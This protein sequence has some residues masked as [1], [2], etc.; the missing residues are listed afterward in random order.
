MTK[1]LTSLAVKNEIERQLAR[2]VVTMAGHRS[3]Q[4]RMQATAIP[5]PPRLPK[6]SA[7]SMMSADS[8]YCPR[9][10][11]TQDEIDLFCVDMRTA[12]TEAETR[13]AQDCSSKYPDIILPDNSSNCTSKTLSPKKKAPP[14]KSR[15]KT[16]SSLHAQQQ[17]AC[18]M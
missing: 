8:H 13:P 11:P 2:I 14:L 1:L 4:K 10:P 16:P 18:S 3:C 9:P 5:S 12:L 7:K 6:P 17:E 15:A